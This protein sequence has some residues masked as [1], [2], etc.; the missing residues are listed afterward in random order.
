MSISTIKDAK[1]VEELEYCEMD[2]CLGVSKGEDHGL[3]ECHPEPCVAIYSD[4]CHPKLCGDY[5]YYQLLNH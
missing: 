5:L 3:H 1:E 4:T 2:D